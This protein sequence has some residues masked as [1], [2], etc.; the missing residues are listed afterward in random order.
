[1]YRTHGRLASSTCL[2]PAVRRR[3][4]ATH[5][6]RASTLRVVTCIRQ[7][8]CDSWYTSLLL[9][10]SRMTDTCTSCLNGQQC[11]MGQHSILQCIA[12]YANKSTANTMFEFVSCKLNDDCQGQAQAWPLQNVQACDPA[13]FGQA[14]QE[15]PC[16][17]LRP[18]QQTSPRDVL[19]HSGKGPGSQQAT[20]ARTNTAHM[21]AVHPG[22][23]L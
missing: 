15:Q 22:F 3:H 17:V 5:Q 14:T 1:M 7:R 11:D 4:A 10:G 13:C 20:P 21:N 2:E 6:P 23:C 12:V 19:P 8:T 16:K 9:R 18:H